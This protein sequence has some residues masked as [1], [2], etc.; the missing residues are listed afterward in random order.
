MKILIKR[1]IQATRV[2][3]QIRYSVSLSVLQQHEND[4][5]SYFSF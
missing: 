4:G 2:C 1:K 3:Y 5:L